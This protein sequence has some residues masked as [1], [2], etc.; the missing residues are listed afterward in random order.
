MVDGPESNLCG[1]VNDE[2]AYLSAL[3]AAFVKRMAC[4]KAVLKVDPESVLKALADEIALRASADAI[5]LKVE[6]APRFSSQVIGAVG[7]TQ[8]AVEG[9]IRCLRVELETRLSRE[10]TLSMD[11]W[12]WLVRH[13]GWLLER[14]HV[15]GNKKTAF[16]DCSG[17]P[18]Q[19]EVMKSAEAALFRLAVSPSGRARNEI[20]QGRVD[21][22]FVRGIWLGKTADP[23]EH[24]F[25]TDTGVYTMRRVKRVPQTKQRRDELVKSFQGT[26]WDRFD[27]ICEIC[28]LAKTARTPCGNRLDARGDR[29]H[30]RQILLRV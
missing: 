11:V 7:R 18:Y 10:V 26:P 2:Y 24:L 19:G 12:P 3:C 20:R 30:H 9:H 22:R 14:Y 28:K 4:A 1:T 13:A 21:A 8:D 27:P 29:V 16:E 25:A 17:K 23:D 6:I 15:N 5:Q